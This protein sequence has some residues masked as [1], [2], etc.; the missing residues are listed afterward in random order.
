[1][2]L[3]AA[4]PDTHKVSIAEP[5][6]WQHPDPLDIAVSGDAGEARVIALWSGSGL[7][8]RELRVLRLMADGGESGEI[9]RSLTVSDGS[10]VSRESA[11]SIE[12]R[13]V[14]KLQARSAANAVAVGLRSGLIR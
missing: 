12:H 10:F 6:R 2:L 1:M 3:L 13:V 4:K 7:T 14:A 9:A 8:S 11:K 5:H